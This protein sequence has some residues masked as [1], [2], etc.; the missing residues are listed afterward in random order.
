M[1]F[2]NKNEFAKTLSAQFKMSANWRASTAKRYNDDRASDAAK[3]LLELESQIIIRDE[4][5][6]HLKPL[7][8][9]PPS[10]AAISKTNRDVGFRT[11]PADFTTWLECLHV[12]LTR[13]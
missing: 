3:R 13:G 8:S 1:L 9:G 11:H 10:L 12:N 5:W 7:V 4:V 6:E 2:Y